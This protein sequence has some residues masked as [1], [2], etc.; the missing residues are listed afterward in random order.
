MSKAKMHDCL[1]IPELVDIICSYLDSP[2]LIERPGDKCDLAVV[3]R[4]CRTFN[5]PAL[6]YLWRSTTLARLLISCMPSDL[7]AVDSVEGAWM[8]TKYI[9][10]LRPI[11]AAD[12]N[13]LRMY[14]PRVKKLSSGSDDWGLEKIFPSLNVAFPDTVLHNLRSLVWNHPSTEFHYIHLFLRPTITDIQFNITCHSASSLLST[15]ASRCPKLANIRIP[16]NSA[17]SRALSHFIAGLLFAQILSVPCLEQDALEYLSELPTLR[18]L[19]LETFPTAFTVSSESAVPTF[20]ALRHFSIT[21]ATTAGMVQFLR[22]CSDV[23]L[24]NLD[25]DLD[26]FPTAAEMHTLLA[27][28][29]AGVSR[30]TLTQLNVHGDG[31][32]GDVA[33]PVVYSIRP[34]TLLLLLCFE[35][36][37]TLRLNSGAGFDLDDESISQMARAWPQII[38]LH[39]SG[40]PSSASDPRATLASLHAIARHCPRIATL[41]IAF[42]GSSVPAPSA[43]NLGAVVRNERLRH[44]NVQHSPITSAIA[45][46]RFLSGVFPALKGIATCR[47]YLDNEDEDELQQHAEAIQRHHCWKEVR[48]LMPEVLAV[49]E[50]EKILAR[51]GA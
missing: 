11:E 36:L 14:A 50:E 45:M 27:A 26:D 5:D 3:A 33:D 21:E 29:A 30:P 9:R 19:A 46:A 38:V 49:R 40:R 24:E 31:D 25:I 39:L 43:A 13:R 48:D 28:V 44:I 41:S 17:N 8:M 2:S 37:T 16:R 4:T 42:D 18:S 35:N 1:K 47:D 20:P 7:W 51:L 10:Q 15:L 32:S 12:W 34:D 22:I 6:D 23:P